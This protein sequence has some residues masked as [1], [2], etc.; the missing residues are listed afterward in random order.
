MS[1]RK[2][3]SCESIRTNADAS[4]SPG[5]RPARGALRALITIHL[6]AESVSR[7]RR[8]VS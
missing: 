1:K 2:E 3:D 8:P 5:T 6:L 4:S 7:V